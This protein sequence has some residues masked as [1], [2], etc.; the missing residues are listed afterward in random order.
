VSEAPP[1]WRVLLDRMLTGLLAVWLVG[2]TLFYLL[3]FSFIVYAE[4][5]SAIH[6][7]F[8]R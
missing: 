7:L 5:E 4:H 6:A 1:A 2:L 3:R 8:G